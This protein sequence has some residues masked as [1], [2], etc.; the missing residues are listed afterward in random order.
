M[1]VCIASS[2]VQLKCLAYLQACLSL[3]SALLASFFVALLVAQASLAQL[4]ATSC[5]PQFVA[6]PAIRLVCLA[7]LPRLFTYSCCKF[8]R[9]GSSHSL[10]IKFAFF[11]YV[12]SACLPA[13]LPSLF[14]KLK[15]SACQPQLVSSTFPACLFS[16]VVSPTP[17]SF[18]T[19]IVCSTR[20]PSLTT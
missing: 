20:L 6:N 14:H 8:F 19:Q 9:P 4:S 18:S 16:Q 17:W 10:S 11:C 13:S 1:H 15:S 7:R 2:S 12:C 5:W 3:S